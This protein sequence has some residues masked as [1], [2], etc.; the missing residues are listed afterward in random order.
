MRQS[1]IT[2]GLTA[3]VLA[4]LLAAPARAIVSSDT[5]STVFT[6]LDISQVIG[7]DAFYQNGY[8]G[9]RTIISNIEA[10]IP[11][12]GQESLSQGQITQ[13]YSAYPINSQ[14]SWSAS[15]NGWTD[16]HA[17]AVSQVMV[18][19]GT[20]T[21]QR[22]IAYGSTL[23]AGA[24]ATDWASSGTGNYSESFDMTNQTFG[25]AYQSLMFFGL[26]GIRTDVV[27]S[28]FAGGSGGY[29]NTFYS[30]SIDALDWTTGKGAAAPAKLV[31]IA[32]GN[33]GPGANSIGYPAD[34]FNALVVGASQTDSTGYSS[35]AS[36]SSRSP[37]AVY[38][39]SLGTLISNARYRIDLVAPGT[40]LTLAAY[41]GATGGNTFGGATYSDTNKYY[42]DEAGTSF[43]SPIA[44]GAGAL[45]IDA[46]KDLFSTNKKAIDARVVKA[47]LM[48]SATKLPGWNNGQSLV[49]GVITTTQSL[50]PAQGAGQL[51]LHSAYSQYTAGTTD[52]S[53]LTGGTVHTLGWDYGSVNAG[54]SNDYS[55]DQA[56]PAGTQFTLTLDW[57]AHDA[58]TIT[59][60]SQSATYVAFDNL[61]LQ[62]Y[63]DVNGTLTLVAQSIS[64][65]NSAEHLYF[66]VPDT[67]NYVF[68]V[69][70][71][72]YNWNG[73]GGS[74]P[75]TKTD[76]GIAWDAAVAPEP[77]SCA[78]LGC[79]SVFLM[80][81]RRK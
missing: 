56:L 68:R 51:N 29:G 80:R 17:T 75:D 14:P 48:N 11:W 46:G 81:R 65:Y 38:D 36:F 67:G 4:L 37:T 42:S 5:G 30:M 64:K 16:R 53:G 62:V 77:G 39:P 33:F 12:A 41:G 26:N 59:D 74:T 60:T 1:R 76:Y 66:N 22:G 32:A 18:G 34:G 70:D 24:I 47:I 31:C 63:E 69:L 61:D 19:E 57:F 7:A 20:Q 23:W 2:A 27:N 50:D 8:T 72:G 3:W 45:V 71:A 79:A 15:P 73:I 10:G 21:W 28:S 55:I 78:L 13:Y 25:E 58:T 6:G 40:N 49:N 9:T 43:S 54:T 52:V 35:V 44:A